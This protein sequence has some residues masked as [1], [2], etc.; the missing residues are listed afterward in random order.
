MVE[1]VIVAAFVL[2][3]LFLAIPIIGKYLDVRTAAVEASRY[4]AWER[5][6]WYG[7]S[8]A[9]T[10]GW[11]GSTNGWKANAKADD[12]I[13][14]E[15][16]VRLLSD[17]GAMD[18]FMDSDMNTNGFKNGNSRSL[19]RARDGSA[20]LAAYTDVANEVGNAKAPGT[21]NKVIDP[22][23]GLAATLGPFTLEMN[24]EYWATVTVN[25][26]D[27]DRAT[28]L[29]AS[30]QLTFA[31]TNV[32]LANGWN[33]EGPDGKTAGLSRAKATSVKNQVA[34]LTPTSIFDNTVT[35]VITTILSVAFPEF[36]KLKLGKIDPDVVPA[37]RVR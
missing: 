25:V 32:L 23:V 16:A 24:G 15:V 33:A 21:L 36:A 28:F 29:P 34:G 10:I 26:S 31:E 14:N 8:S 13:R 30:S 5:T 35:D 3:P 27:Y 7:G 20:L 4:A 11:F 37:D 17:T 6:V 1:L 9:S 18:S 22:I 2:V 19:W 12:K